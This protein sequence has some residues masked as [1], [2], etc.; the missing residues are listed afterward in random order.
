MG[1]LLVIAHAF[2]N[3]FGITPPGPKGERHIALYIGGLLGLIVLGM[4]AAL[5]AFLSIKR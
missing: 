5:V 2:I 1:F 3:T 4:I